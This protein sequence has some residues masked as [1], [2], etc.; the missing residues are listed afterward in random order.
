MLDAAESKTNDQ[1]VDP[2]RKDADMIAP[3]T[4]MATIITVADKGGS[5]YTAFA[6]AGSVTT[7]R[8]RGEQSGLRPLAWSV[9]GRF[10]RIEIA[11]RARAAVEGSRLRHPEVAPVR[12]SR[13]TAVDA[14]VLCGHPARGVAGQEGDHSG[15]LCG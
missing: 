13:G 11:G 14:D 6:G 2:Q 15:D 7:R 10:W 5:T 8:A 12:R 4:A 3:Q 9:S 1:A